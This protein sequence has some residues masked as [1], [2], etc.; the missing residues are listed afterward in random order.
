MSKTLHLYSSDSELPGVTGS[1]GLLCEL[2]PDSL[3]LRQASQRYEPEELLGS[4]DQALR[5]AHQLVS[6]LLQASPPIDGLALLSVYEEPLLEEFG[7]LAQAFHLD[8]WIAERGFSTCRFHSHSPWSGRLRQV[9]SVRGSRYELLAGK[10]QVGG[11][12]AMRT[13]SKLWTAHPTS[14]EILQRV[15]PGWSR[16]GSSIPARAR[17]RSAPKGGAWFYSTAYNFTRI[18]LAYEVY[19]P[20]K[21]NFL[22]EDSATGGKGLRELGRNSYPLYAWSRA[23]DFPSAPEVR[24]TGKRIGAAVAAV[25]LAGEESLLREVFLR[26]DH[27]RYFLRR[28]LP[29]VLYTSRVIERWCKAV[30]PE[31]IVVGNAGDERVLLMRDSTK[32]VPVVML[33]HGVMHW[34][35]AVADQPVDLFLLRGPFFQRVIDDRLRSK[36][37]VL[38][39]PEPA[40]QSTE[41]KRADVLFITAPCEILPL[42]HPEDRRDI[43]RSLLR[44]SHASRRRLVLRV[45]PMEK[46]AAY[47]KEVAALQA[48][49]GSAVEVQ[50]SQGP[51]A[52]QVLA[53]TCVAVLHFSTMFLDCLRHGIPI[54]SFGWHWFPNKDRFAE[55]RIF[56][57]ASDL[58]HLEELLRQGV[59]GRLPPRSGGIQEFLAP[60]QPDLISKRFQEIR[61]FRKAVAGEAPHPLT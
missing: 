57:F 9:R 51:G 30:S 22:V 24:A 8:R 61:K 2:A 28:N 14:S 13:I 58:A 35:Y 56:N 49:L 11:G 52:E 44:V 60:S 59:E 43:L 25:P 54:I 46:I 3:S 29:L 47:K 53:R 15:A 40:C 37:I 31:L 45:H 7:R 34:T 5:V 20:E 10:A 26:S 4:A 1:I 19:M 32:D 48:E 27:W 16:L 33:Q 41:S 23:S 36:S 42:F 50:Y 6:K 21:L 17:A 55:E 12:P 39:F 38:N 18:G